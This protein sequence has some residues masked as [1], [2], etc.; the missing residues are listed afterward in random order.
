MLKSMYVHGASEYTKIGYP[1]NGAY[2][3]VEGKSEKMKTFGVG[4]IFFL[5]NGQL[6]YRRLYSVDAISACFS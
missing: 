1:E 6:L 3:L 4:T 2:P 5:R